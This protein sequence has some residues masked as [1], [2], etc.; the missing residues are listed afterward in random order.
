MPPP[1]ALRVGPSN[2]DSAAAPLAK[3]LDGAKFMA[4]SLRLAGVAVGLCFPA[5]IT[6]L[7]CL[8][9]CV[10]EPA[11]FDPRVFQQ[12]ERAQD[13][14]VKSQPMYP[15][16]TTQESRFVPGESEVRPVPLEDRSNV[17]EGPPLKMSLQEAIH[18]AVVDSLDIRVASYDTAVDQTRV[19]EAQ[20][21]FDPTVFAGYQFERVD[22]L[23]GI[24]DATVPIP[25]TDPSKATAA[26]F[27]SEV[28]D[29]D[30]EAI[31]TAQFGIRQNTESGGQMELKQTVTNNWFD[32]ARSFINPYFDNELVLTITQPVL[33]NY[34]VDVNRARITISQNNQRVSLLD[35]RKTVEDTV[36]Q[37]EK[38][39]WQLVAAQE[40]VDTLKWLVQK[41]EETTDVLFH[42][43]QTDVSA[44]QIQ[45]SNSATATRQAD[46]KQAQAKV[47]DLSDQLK[48][49]ISDPDYPV[50]SA[51]LIAPTDAGTDLPLHFDLDEAI[52]TG[53]ENRLELGQQ[54]VRIQSSE[55]ALKVAKNNLLPTLNLQGSVTVDGLSGNLGDA[56]DIEGNFNHIG[57]V[58]GFEFEFP[59]GNRAARAIWQRAILQ[60]QQA[61]AS[62]KELTDKAALEIKTA[63]RAVDT[64]WEV[65]HKRRDARFAATKLV[66][67]FERQQASGDLPFTP[68]TVNLRLQYQETLAAAEE[69]EHQAMSDYNFAIANLEKSKGTVLRYNNIRLEEAR[70]PQ[71]GQTSISPWPV[72]QSGP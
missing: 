33:Q 4:K 72:G 41:S 7:G 67:D 39:Y 10:E 54:Q 37:I 69:A 70:L 16:P 43:Q 48:Q 45:Q 20:G 11:P 35:F 32:P 18:R 65:L 5:V 57:F 23:T 31:S 3:D 46:L 49:L 52:E 71:G 15:L 42:R 68:D 14:Q 28:V 64:S 66:E 51:A 63:A 19:M 1:Q 36:L 55:V 24:T 12:W 21:H 40:D 25:G 44:V 30:R 38:T 13:T 8:V 17:P 6:L 61:I 34:G 29:F 50:S 47:G 2:T 59:L 27:T 58:A 53:L 26:D 22:K 56:F 62:Y 60:R 9:G